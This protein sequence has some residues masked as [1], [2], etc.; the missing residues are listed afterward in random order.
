[1]VNCIQDLMAV[2]YLQ[3]F[4]GGSMF[5]LSGLFLKVVYFEDDKSRLV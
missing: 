1:M 3:I 5:C 4:L 2:R